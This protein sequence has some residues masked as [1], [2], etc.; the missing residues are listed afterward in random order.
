MAVHHFVVQVRA[1]DAAGAA[2]EADTVAPLHLLAFLHQDLAQVSIAGA[3][4]EAVLDLHVQAVPLVLVDGFHHGAVPGGVDRIAGRTG[5][6]H[7]RVHFAVAIQRVG[8][9]AEGTGHPVGGR[10][11]IHGRDARDALGAVAGRAGKRGHVVE[12]LRLHKGLFFKDIQPDYQAAER[13]VAVQYVQVGVAVHPAEAGVPHFAGHL[14]HTI[15]R[16]VDL[17]VA[18]LQDLQLLVELV[19]LGAHAL[20]AGGPVGAAALQ[21]GGFGKVQAQDGHIEPQVQKEKGGTG[22][23]YRQHLQPAVPGFFADLDDEGFGI[24]YVLFNL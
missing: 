11:R 21:D 22:K 5:E 10:V 23:Q 6:V 19:Q 2:A 7:A 24:Q 14:V 15:D 3:V 4:A 1:G 12:G 9:I 17:V 20:D 16:A 18:H 13:M 8:A